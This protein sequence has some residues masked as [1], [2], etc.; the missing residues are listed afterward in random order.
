MRIR[1]TVIVFLLTLLAVPALV[2]PASAGGRPDPP[3]SW[4]ETAIVVALLVVGAFCVLVVAF[5]IAH[6]RRHQ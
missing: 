5:G 2:A 4:L 1:R 3:P 6:R